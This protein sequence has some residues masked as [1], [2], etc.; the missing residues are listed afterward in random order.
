MAITVLKPTINGSIKSCH[1]LEGHW[2]LKRISWPL[3]E[4]AEWSQWY[5]RAGWCIQ[6][7]T[8]GW[9]Y[10]L[11]VFV[12]LFIVKILTIIYLQQD[13]EDLA[14]HCVPSS[15]ADLCAPYHQVHLSHHVDLVG[16][17]EGYNCQWNRTEGFKYMPVSKQEL[18]HEL[19]R[20]SQHIY[21]HLLNPP[22]RNVHPKSFR[23]GPIRE[24]PDWDPRSRNIWNF[25]S[26][27]FWSP[28]LST[29]MSSH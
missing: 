12:V 19:Y 14:I 16:P 29:V 13:Q 5:E 27:N 26:S 18:K 23:I 7:S 8:L 24:N 6:S 11:W 17:R 21:L 3:T 22:R 28:I 20:L 2:V 15:Q 10:F 1:L 25:L 9:P 4:A